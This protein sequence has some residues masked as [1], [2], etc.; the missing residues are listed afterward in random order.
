MLNDK[1]RS[2]VVIN[3]KKSKCKAIEFYVDEGD[4]KKECK[5]VECASVQLV[6]ELTGDVEKACVMYEKLK[7]DR[8]Y[9]EVMYETLVDNLKE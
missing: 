1:K 4:H 9:T 3:N 8:I 2:N 7:E 6:K 5:A